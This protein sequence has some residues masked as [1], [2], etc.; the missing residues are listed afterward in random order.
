MTSKWRKAFKI[1]AAAAVA[2]GSGVALLYTT[3]VVNGERK[4][5][6]VIISLSQKDFTDICDADPEES[7]SYWSEQKIK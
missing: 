2:G 1:G 5:E 7:G 6:Q 3:S 4:K